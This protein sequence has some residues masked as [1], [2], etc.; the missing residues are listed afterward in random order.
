[1]AFVGWAESLTGGGREAG[2][3]LLPRLTPLLCQHTQLLADRPTDGRTENG[4]RMFPIYSRSNLANITITAFEMPTTFATRSDTRPS[5]K[6]DLAERRRDRVSDG[7]TVCG[8][9][10]L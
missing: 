3:H 9:E 2:Q 1:M 8:E 7:P 4:A 5:K 6:H 10:G